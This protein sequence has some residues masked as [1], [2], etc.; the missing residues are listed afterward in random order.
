LAVHA[1]GKTNATY[2]SPAHLDDI[3]QVN[4]TSEAGGTIGGGRENELKEVRE[5]ARLLTEEC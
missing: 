3:L 5:E 2:I 1:S 4:R